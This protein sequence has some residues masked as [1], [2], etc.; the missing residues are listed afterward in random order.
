MYYVGH[1]VH[2]FMVDRGVVGCN[3]IELPMGAW[4]IR[5][6]YQRGNQPGRV[7][8]CQIEVDVAWNEFIVHAPDDEWSTIAPFRILSFDIECA[9]RPG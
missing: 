9:G 6:D 4:S 7:S 1:F 5:P 3:W 8:R 2:R